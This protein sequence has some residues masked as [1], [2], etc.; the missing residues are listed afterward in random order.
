MLQTEF[1]RRLEAERLNPAQRAMLKLRMDLL[2]SFLR[3][4]A[5]NLQ[6]YFAPGEMTLVDLT[7]PFL[8]GTYCC[9]SI[10]AILTSVQV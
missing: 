9:P 4:A 8:D 1:K 3:P 2:E 6:S 10:Q 7:D 5:P